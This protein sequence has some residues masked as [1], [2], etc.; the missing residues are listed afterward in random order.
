MMSGPAVAF[1]SPDGESDVGAP[2]GQNASD[3]DG[4]GVGVKSAAESNDDVSGPGIF[5]HNPLQ[6]I[7][8]GLA[9]VTAQTTR[10]ATVH[11]AGD[12]TPR[13]RKDPDPSSA[14]P[15]DSVGSPEA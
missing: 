14:E 2:A 9:G 3:A 15:V 10:G 1:A 4:A 13:K 12:A 8:T 7:L 6:K 5:R 11:V